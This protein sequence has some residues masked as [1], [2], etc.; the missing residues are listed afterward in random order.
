MYKL[1]FSER[2]DLL[3][4]NN[5]RISNAIFIAFSYVQRLTK[6]QLECLDKSEHLF[7]GPAVLVNVE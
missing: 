3:L 7:K 5:V 4:Q 2:H 6:F 1:H